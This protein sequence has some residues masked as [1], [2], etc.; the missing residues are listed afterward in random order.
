MQYITEQQ[1]DR[2]TSATG[3]RLRKEEKVLLTIA[4]NG[5]GRYWEGGI[6]GHFFR[7]R[8]GEP[9]ELPK[10]LAKLISENRAVVQEGRRKV[11][12]FRGNGKKL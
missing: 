3:D 7:I 9:V 11:R 1:I 12:A 4:D 2:L 6:N 8:V 5:T 10:S